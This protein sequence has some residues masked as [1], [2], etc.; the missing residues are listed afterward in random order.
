MT[1][2]SICLGYI[3]KPENVKV[4][5]KVIAG[6]RLHSDYKGEWQNETERTN[7]MGEDG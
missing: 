1:L 6:R 5:P 7:F 2:V 3:M 4:N